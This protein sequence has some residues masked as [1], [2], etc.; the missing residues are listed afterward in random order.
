MRLIFLTLIFGAVIIIGCGSDKMSITTS[1]EEALANFQQGRDLVERVRVVDSKTY[2]E[3]AVE[4]DSSFALAW[5]YLSY[6]QA[7]ISQRFDH[8]EKSR[9]LADGVSEGERIYILSAYYGFHGDEKKELLQE[10]RIIKL[11]D[12]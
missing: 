7:D 8:I 4:L 9:S 1:N 5:L 2:F 11:Q 6:T 10:M 3:N 12:E